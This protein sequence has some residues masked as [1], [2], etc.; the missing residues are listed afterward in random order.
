MNEFLNS[1]GMLS[2]R[3][4]TMLLISS[5]LFGCAQPQPQN[6][7]LTVLC[8]LPA[9]LNEKD[10]VLF[11]KGFV[12]RCEF[13]PFLTSQTVKSTREMGKTNGHTVYF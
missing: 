8:K 9:K 1:R 13:W 3:L 2:A 4:L 5:C 10:S 7:R 12:R 6:P 11:G